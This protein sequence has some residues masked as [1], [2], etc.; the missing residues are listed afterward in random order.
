MN[1]FI[2]RMQSEEVSLLKPP[3]LKSQ[4]HE[5]C[6]QKLSVFS[7]KTIYIS[8]GQLIMLTATFQKTFK[9]KKS[10]IPETSA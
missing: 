10:R 3:F 1:A 5:I 4:L 8:L 2:T 9:G 7:Q 6:R